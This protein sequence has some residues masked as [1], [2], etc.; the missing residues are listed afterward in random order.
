[1]T[2]RRHLPECILVLE[3]GL[4]CG[5]SS[6]MLLAWNFGTLETEQEILL[7]CGKIVLIQNSER[8]RHQTITTVKRTERESVKHTKSTIPEI[9]GRRP[10]FRLSRDAL[11]LVFSGYSPV[12]F[13]LRIHPAAGGYRHI[14]RTATWCTSISFN[15]LRPS[16]NS[17][18]RPA[19]LQAQDHRATHS[20][21]NDSFRS[22]HCRC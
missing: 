8:T 4:H 10:Y 5:P 16:W 17:Q 2:T 1:M 18:N 11:C 21:H 9:E 12:Q 22:C 3:T 6:S 15:H 19:L 7:Y 14:T 20:I 13:G